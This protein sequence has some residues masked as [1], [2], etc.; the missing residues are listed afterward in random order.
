MKIS[1]DV[2]IV[3]LSLQRKYDAEY[4]AIDNFLR[5]KHTNLCMEYEES[6]KVIYAKLAGIRKYIFN[7]ELPIS[8]HK[9]GKFLIILRTRGDK[10]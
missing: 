5:S 9:R 7:H 10:K 2:D 6:D 8:V 1:H 4:K 3:E